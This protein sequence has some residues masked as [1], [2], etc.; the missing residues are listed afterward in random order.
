MRMSN[1]VSRYAFCLL[2]YVRF[3]EPFELGAVKFLPLSKSRDSMPADVY[4][5]LQRVRGTYLDGRNEVV[6]DLTLAYSDPL[7]RSSYGDADGRP[8]GRRSICVLPLYLPQPNTPGSL[9]PF[10]PRPVRGT[11]EE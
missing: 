2:P 5:Y 3:A 7:I 4:D 6:P 1:E 8:S 11:P 10:P 9:G